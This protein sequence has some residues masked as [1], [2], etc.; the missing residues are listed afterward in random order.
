MRVL[1][2]S[3]VFVWAKSAPENLS[4]EARAALI[5]PGNEVFLSLA[6]AWELWIKHAK[7]PIVALAP[8][9][10]SGAASLLRAARESGVGLLEITLEHAAAAAALPAVHRDPFDRM[11]IAQAIAERLTVVTADAVFRRYKRLRVLQA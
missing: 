6:S 1:L 8:L 4:E 9:L 2:D 7:K 11:L 10:D 3:H 5:D